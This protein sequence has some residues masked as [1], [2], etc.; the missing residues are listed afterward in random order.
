MKISLN[1]GKK[2]FDFE[3]PC[4]IHLNPGLSLPRL[5]S[6]SI[7]TKR[8]VFLNPPRFLKMLGKSVVDILSSCQL[9]EAELKERLKAS[10]FISRLKAKMESLSDWD[11]LRLITTWIQYQNPLCVHIKG[12]SGFHGNQSSSLYAPFL[13]HL[14]HKGQFLVWEDP[15]EL[16][17][18]LFDFHVDESGV[19]ALKDRFPESMDEIRF[20]EPQPYFPF[21]LRFEDRASGAIMQIGQL[22]FLLN[23]DER[24]KSLGFQNHELILF[25]CQDSFEFS[26]KERQGF[27]KISLRSQTHIGHSYRQCFDFAGTLFWHCSEKRSPVPFLQLRPL[28]S[29]AYIF[30]P[31]SGKRLLP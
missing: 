17:G 28:L 30:Q 25:L 27:Q 3:Q 21:K 31:E 8:Q 23:P 7:E 29:R 18:G 26:R 13:C 5:R 16:P 1:L 19:T 4:S 9:P 2:T 10:P 14:Q 15:K 12:F 22:E 24:L 6:K 11:R 20:F